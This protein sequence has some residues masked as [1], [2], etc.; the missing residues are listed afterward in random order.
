M[1]A[2][3]PGWSKVDAARIFIL[4][5]IDF[6]IHFG[7]SQNELCVRFG[8]RRAPLQTLCNELAKIFIL[9][10]FCFNYRFKDLDVL[11]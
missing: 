1:F 3:F 7:L 6:E 10:L 4:S 11:F 8:A 2:K 5:T 9:S